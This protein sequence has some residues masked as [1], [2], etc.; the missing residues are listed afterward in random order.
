VTESVAKR[1]PFERVLSEN[2]TI[3]FGYQDGHA[4]VK[5]RTPIGVW[6][7]VDVPAEAILK[8]KENFD[9]AYTYGMKPEGERTM[10]EHIEFE[11]RYDCRGRWGYRDGHVELG[12]R[13][14]LIWFW[15]TFPFEEFLLAKKAMDE[16]HLWAELPE[17]VRKMQGAE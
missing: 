9:Q 13:E 12:V 14:M 10:K 11:A 4:L 15:I 5:A 3:L 7:S 1:E 16:A 6:Y 8:F 2:V 17:D